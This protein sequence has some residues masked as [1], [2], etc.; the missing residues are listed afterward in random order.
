[1]KNLTLILL[2]FISNLSWGQTKLN[3]TLKKQLDSVMVL[4]QKYRDTLM[5][6][7]NPQKAD[8][9]AKSLSFN[10]GQATTHYWRL[11]NRLDSLNVVFIEATFKRYGYPGKTMVDTPA[12][13]SAWYI[14]QHSTKIHQYIA[15]MKKAA[16]KNEIPFHL[17]VM[18][19]DRD[20]MNQGKEQVYGTQVVCHQF[21]N[22]KD[23]CIVWPIKYPDKINQRRK[24]AGF[25]STVEENATRLGV[26]Y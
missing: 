10:V 8:S 18:M 16:D 11:Q 23:A 7:M 1:M 12:N 19:L 26:I 14:V 3:T 2:L 13:E 15:L 6:L 21:K 22:I 5:L 9:V 20:L 17:Y 24:K 4:D 25:P